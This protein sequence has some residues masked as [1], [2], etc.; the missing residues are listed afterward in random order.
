MAGHASAAR[1]TT[2]TASDAIGRAATNRDHRIQPC[3]LPS[4][5]RCLGS[6]R[7]SFSIRGPSIPSSAGSRVM[8]PATATSTTSAE[9]YPSAV[10]SG[11]FTIASDSKATITVHPANTTAP[12]DVAVARATDSRTSIPSR[13]CARCRVTMNS[14]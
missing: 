12:P 11:S 3:G 13:T 7:R 5:C 10:T 2:A 1:I 8:A 6:G 14:A 9:V 4:S